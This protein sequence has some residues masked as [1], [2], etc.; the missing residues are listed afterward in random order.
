M[1]F[2]H[3]PPFERYIKKLVEKPLKNL[4]QEAV[5]DILTNPYCGQIK[6][7][8]LQGFWGY[9]IQ[10]KGINYE[11]AY[12]IIENDDGSPQSVV[13]YMAGT[14]ENFWN[15]IKRYLR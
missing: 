7:G 9:D 6:V 3:R 5:M 15:E 13:F 10:Y 8:D 1:P 11:I 2:F 12:V 14:R 4:F